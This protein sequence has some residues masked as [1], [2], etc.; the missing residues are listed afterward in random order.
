M[1]L[2]TGKDQL[3]VGKRRDQSDCPGRDPRTPTPKSFS[4]FI[5][6]ARCCGSRGRFILCCRGTAQIDELVPTDTLYRHGR[7]L[8]RKRFR[9]DAGARRRRQPGRLVGRGVFCLAELSRRCSL[10]P[11]EQSTF[12]P[13]PPATRRGRWEALS[14]R[15]VSLSWRCCQ[16]L[17]YADARSRARRGKWFESFDWTSEKKREQSR[18]PA[19][20]GD[21]RLSPATPAQLSRR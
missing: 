11:H 13:A 14:Y 21:Y 10:R 17:G 19:G 5:A 20:N 16:R 7:C 1:N 4:R 18:N 12:I 15:L 6:R 9:F 2:S 8:A 3:A